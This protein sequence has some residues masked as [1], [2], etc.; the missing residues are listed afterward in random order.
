MSGLPAGYDNWRISN[1]EDDRCEFCGVH[2][3]ECRGGW[4]PDRCTGECGRS[5]RDPDYER[6]LRMEDEWLDRRFGGRAD[7]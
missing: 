1:P 7:D 4:Q 6:D 5:W 3:R 2:P